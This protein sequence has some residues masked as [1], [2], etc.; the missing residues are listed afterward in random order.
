MADRGQD[1]LRFFTRRG[2]MMQPTVIMAF[3]RQT[4]SARRAI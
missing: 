3:V 4:R 1:V 2:K